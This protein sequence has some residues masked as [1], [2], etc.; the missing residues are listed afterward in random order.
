[1]FVVPV[2]YRILAPHVHRPREEGQLTLTLGS[3]AEPAAGGLQR[4]LALVSLDGAVVDAIHVDAHRGGQLGDSE[5]IAPYTTLDDGI[6][7]SG[8]GDPSSAATHHPFPS[9]SD[10]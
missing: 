5:F 2:M 6:H 3:Q 1:L 10:D 4:S 7:H 9:P 8:D